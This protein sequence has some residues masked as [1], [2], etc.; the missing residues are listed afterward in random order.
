MA[1]K[2]TKRYIEVTK[3]DTITEV[4][5]LSGEPLKLSASY[6]GI[7]PPN[8]NNVLELGCGRGEY[9]IAMS[10]MFPEK[11]FVG[12]DIKGDRLIIGSRKVRDEKLSR[13]KF[14]RILAEHLNTFFPENMFDEI[15]IPFPDPHPGQKSGNK[16]LTSERFLDIFRH[17]LKKS[18]TIHLKTDCDIMFNF[19]LETAQKNGNVIEYTKDLYN[20]NLI[21]RDLLQIQTTYE[22]RYLEE[23]RTIK[24][25]NFSL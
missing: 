8:G 22:K 11:N 6:D 5:V 16:R 14:F 20:S 3:S 25:L 4:I 2:K 1:R 7:F 17:I 19:S 23:N 12:V 18:G 9:T 10:K 13:I 24:Y 21:E 15:W